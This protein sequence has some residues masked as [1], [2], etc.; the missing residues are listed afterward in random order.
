MR[1]GQVL[2]FFASTHF[3]GGLKRKPFAQALILATILSHW[4]LEGRPRGFFRGMLVTAIEAVLNVKQ[5]WCYILN[6]IRSAIYTEAASI[7]TA[8]TKS[9]S[10]LGLV[11]AGRHAGECAAVSS[12]V[13][14][15]PLR[16][17]FGSRGEYINFAEEPHHSAI[18]KKKPKNISGVLRA[19][20]TNLMWEKCPEC[21]IVVLPE[22]ADIAPDATL[23]AKAFCP[24]ITNIG[25]AAVYLLVLVVYSNGDVT[26]RERGKSARMYVGSQS[27]QKVSACLAVY[28]LINA[29]E[30]V[31]GLDKDYDAEDNPD[32][33]HL[34]PMFSQGEETFIRA[35]IAREEDQDASPRSAAKIAF[36]NTVLSQIRSDYSGSQQFVN[37]EEE[38]ASK[39]WA[40]AQNSQFAL[41]HHWG[42]LLQTR[43][44]ENNLYY[45][46]KPGKLVVI[47]P[48]GDLGVREEVVDIPAHGTAAQLHGQNVASLTT[49]PNFSGV[50]AD[51]TECRV[52]YKIL[53]A[54]AGD[55]GHLMLCGPA[56]LFGN[57]GTVLKKA[58]QL[59]RD[60]KT[61]KTEAVVV[62][63]TEPIILL[64]VYPRDVVQARDS[65][66]SM[67]AKVAAVPDDAAFAGVQ[68]SS[69]RLGPYPTSDNEDE[70]EVLVVPIVGQ[71]KIRVAVKVIIG[72]FFANVQDV[73]V[74]GVPLPGVRLY[75]SMVGQKLRMDP[76]ECN[77][78]LKA[79]L[80][81]AWPE[82]TVKMAVSRRFRGA[83]RTIPIGVGVPI[84]R[85]PLLNAGKNIDL[86]FE[87]DFGLPEKEEDG[88]SEDGESEDAPRRKQRRWCQQ[89]TITGK[90]E[91]HIGGEIV[92][93]TDTLRP[94]A[95]AAHVAGAGWA[96]YTIESHVPSST[97]MDALT[98]GVSK[99]KLYWHRLL[100]M[101]KL[102]RVLSKIESGVKLKPN[103]VRESELGK[104]KRM[105]TTENL[106]DIA[107]LLRKIVTK[108]Q[109]LA[110][111]GGRFTD[112]DFDCAREEWDFNFFS[113][114][115]RAVL[116]AETGK[117]I[118]L[119]D[120]EVLAQ[121]ES[122]LAMIRLAMSPRAR[123]LCVP[124]DDYFATNFQFLNLL[125]RFINEVVEPELQR[126]SKS[127][128]LATEKL[129]HASAINDAAKAVISAVSQTVVGI[130][131]TQYGN[132]RG[133]AIFFDNRDRAARVKLARMKAE[134]ESASLARRGT[135]EL[136]QEV[137][138]RFQDGTGR[139]PHEKLTTNR[140]NRGPFYIQAVGVNKTFGF[141]G[142]DEVG[143]LSHICPAMLTPG[144][145][146]DGLI[147]KMIEKNW[148]EPGWDCD[149]FFQDLVEFIGE[150]LA[151][152]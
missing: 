87:L 130:D 27:A 150:K 123:L 139:L 3:D 108:A 73:E 81:H 44:L 106:R 88:E 29:S 117:L 41:I 9:L 56:D 127:Q 105:P 1:P 133:A 148:L 91:K 61:E 115:A 63:T 36:L 111:A 35:E 128:D 110:N 70:A 97:R 89:D 68:V 99:S 62:I 39:Q 47:D 20:K 84:G 90:H 53:E 11:S 146:L 132:R 82:S 57:S 19:G 79:V 69:N 93:V 34:R 72:P 24:T 18:R 30:Y 80:K 40:L 102:E 94:H 109:K 48:F 145:A 118:D 142:N 135:E 112:A 149:K 14:S 66:T 134:R 147:E 6:L 38:K 141:V 124:F 138:Q 16:K 104:R 151:K 15:M 13:E 122:P 71:N 75:A 7:F 86:D 23:D 103:I 100:H 116:A 95:G 136:R 64:A 2:R 67:W 144:V 26:W 8:C 45:D 17:I 60:R 22:E 25:E 107:S 31:N 98:I 114:D 46:P 58:R 49:G 4:L 12:L 152:M 55:F 92:T 42:R 43:C 52:N 101:M 140:K 85:Y 50:D 10:F 126:V 28:V 51:L 143:A 21:M 137:L 96:A 33:H 120:P 125:D 74:A 78:F 76:S 83:P 131:I 121:L 37:E 54:L 65:E 59:L 119:M 77:E 32:V 129:R 113:N 5:N